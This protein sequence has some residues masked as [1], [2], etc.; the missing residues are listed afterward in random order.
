MTAVQVRLV[1]LALAALAGQPAARRTEHDA[2]STGHDAL[3][4]RTEHG[5]PSTQHRLITDLDT[6]FADPIFDR[7]LVGVRVESLSTGEVLYERDAGRH[8]MP[9]SNMK[10]VTLAVAAERLGW[11]FRF[12]T[13]LEAAGPIRDGVLHGD[14]IVAGGGDPSIG[15]ADADPSPLFAG[16]VVALRG[17]GIRRINGRLV[18]DDDAFE[19]EGRGGG[20][21]WDYLTAGY[22]A[23]SGA[24]SYNENVAVIRARPGERDGAPALVLVTPPGHGFDVTTEVTTTAAG[25]RGTLSVARASGSPRLVARGRIPAGAN[26]IVRTTTVDNPTLFFVR[27]LAGTLNAYGLTVR[28][29]AWDIDELETPVPAGERRVVVRHQSPPLSALSGYLM[30]VSQNFY[31]ETMLKAIGRAASGAGSENAG[32]R[33]VRGTLASWGIPEDAVVVYDGSGL[34]RYNYVTAG[35]IVEILRRMWE[36]DVHRGP[37][38]ATLPVGGHDGTLALRMRN[39][40]LARHVQ[41]KTGSIANVRALSGYLDRPSGEKLVFSIIAN[42]FT[43][44]SREVDALVERAL[45]RFLN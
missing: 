18:G 22:A 15:S 31:A 7:A 43:A 9:A 27:S 10:L 28:D 36:S 3:S 30:K 33:A 4:T 8:V 45:V 1:A 24:L 17:A 11:D 42:H 20:W 29:G 41:A 26:E 32:R 40:D 19:D 6:I 39:T 38:L 44:P 13:R 5:A 34:S 2:R 12:E 23:P 16:W 35:A 21:S 37:F 14:L 25:G